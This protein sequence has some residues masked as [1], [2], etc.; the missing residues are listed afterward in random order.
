[1]PETPYYIT[2][3]A[4]FILILQYLLFAVPILLGLYAMFLNKNKIKSYQFVIPAIVATVF[5]L[6]FLYHLTLVIFTREQVEFQIKQVSFPAD[7]LEPSSVRS[8]NKSS[9]VA[10]KIVT[11]KNENFYFDNYNLYLFDLASGS[12]DNL[13]IGQTCKAM[14]YG[15]QPKFIAYISCP[16]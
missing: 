14:K 2:Y 7:I 12:R 6:P 5:L 1:M 3:F 10:G 8:E 11:A 15:F 13:K 4:A 9:Y 16:N